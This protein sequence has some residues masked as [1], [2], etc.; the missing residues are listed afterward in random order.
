MLRVLL[1][2]E[3]DLSAMLAPTLVG[4]GAIDRFRA[5]RLEEIRQLSVALSPQVILV[6]RDLPHA[7]QLIEALR[8]DPRTR[9]RSIA[10]LAHGD[11]DPVE[12]EL[13]ATGANAILRLPPDAQWDA[14]LSRLLNVASRQDGRLDIRLSVEAWPAGSGPRQADDA[15]AVLTNLSPSGMLLETSTPLRVGHEI[16]FR[17]A[18]G[19]RDEVAGR[20]RV[21]RESRPGV[22]GVEFID[23][24]EAARARLR[25]YVR[26]LRLEAEFPS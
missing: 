11:L 14:R 19:P 22:F 9:G 20:G 1:C 3:A 21:V 4:R 25:D 15:S 2:S 24:G 13:L 12:V 18:L 17:L 8:A 6:D 5:A 10:I 16:G 26:S 7:R 23:I